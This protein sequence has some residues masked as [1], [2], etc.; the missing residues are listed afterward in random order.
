MASTP[1]SVTLIS[2]CLKAAA[3]RETLYPAKVFFLKEIVRKKNGRT[4]KQTFGKVKALDLSVSHRRKLKGDPSLQ[5]NRKWLRQL[6]PPQPSLPSKP[7]SDEARYFSLC[8]WTK[9]A[10]SFHQL[11]FYFSISFFKKGPQSP[12]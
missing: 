3:A 7:R 9:V 4:G 10:A 6:L 2:F 5:E 12:R 11:V 1:G 8:L